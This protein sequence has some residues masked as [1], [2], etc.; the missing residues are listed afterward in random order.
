MKILIDN[1]HGE[2]T[3]GK[4]SPDGRLREY[5][6][7]R[8][9]ANM[10]CIELKKR[11]YDAERIVRESI[12]VPLSGRVQRVNEECRELGKSNVLLVS[13]HN[14]ACGNGAEWCDARGFSVRVSMNASVKSKRLAQAIYA[15]AEKR[16][17]QGNRCVPAERYWVQN[18][19]IC[20]D[21]LCAA[22]LT[23]NLFQDNMEDVKFLLSAEGKKA[24]VNI[25]VD[26]IISYIK[27]LGK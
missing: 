6:Y 8:E 16:G 14:D 12:D 27:S 15:E 21:S 22:V 11:G 13:I 5:A 18:L 26:G 3:P 19:A 20:R 7:T 2:N 17:L 9:I 10:V 25:H 4:R 24:I 23:E 1:G